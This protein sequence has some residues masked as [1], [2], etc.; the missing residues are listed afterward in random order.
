MPGVGAMMGGSAAGL[1]WD[2]SSSSLGKGKEKPDVLRLVLLMYVAQVK[3]LYKGWGH[4][5]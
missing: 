1:L 5:S 2:A 4:L 3:A